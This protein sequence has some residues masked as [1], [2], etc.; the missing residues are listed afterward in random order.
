MEHDAARH[1]DA[2][3]LR[4]HSDGAKVTGDLVL[5]E[6]QFARR[7]LALLKE[8]T[9]SSRM[10]SPTDHADSGHRA[11]ALTRG[12]LPSGV[13]NDL[14]SAVMTALVEEVASLRALTARLKADN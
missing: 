2:V 4:V 6:A 9:P 10:L 1:C 7:A 5:W 14:R 3:G 12:V 11:M 13:D 8:L